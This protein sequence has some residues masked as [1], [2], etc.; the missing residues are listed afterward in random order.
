MARFLEN[1]LILDQRTSALKKNFFAPRAGWIRTVRQSLRMSQAELAALLQINQKSV[2][3][4]EISEVE[5]R[6]RLESLAKVANALG[7]DLVYALVPRKPLAQTYNERARTI[8]LDQIR[9]VENSMQLE[10]QKVNFSDA[11]VK[12]L[13]SK[14]IEKDAVHW[15]I[16]V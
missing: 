16:D 14:L 3:S 9:G 8:A 4:L 1:Q 2:H 12:K 11:A 10:N 15:S 5:Q 13:A 7:C 6:I